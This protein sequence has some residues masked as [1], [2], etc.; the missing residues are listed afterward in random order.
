MNDGIMD[1]YIRA[2]RFIYYLMPQFI[3]YNND[4]LLQ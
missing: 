2:Y 4:T 1:S 3:H